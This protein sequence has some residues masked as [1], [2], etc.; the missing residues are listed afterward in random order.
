MDK[1]QC[2][3]KQ[4]CLVSN[5][6]YEATITSD[7]TNYG[8]KKYIGLCETTFKK[9]YA[10]HKTSFTHPKYKKSTT[11]S[12]EYWKVKEANRNPKI[13][14]KILK[15]SRAFSPGH[16]S[17]QLCQEEKYQIATYPSNNLLNKKTEIVSQCRHMNKFYLATYDSRD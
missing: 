2:P 15:T 3:M 5:V 1:D 7:I 11:L 10:S 17:C 16:N 8:E 12:T 4:N 13:D 6:I 14:W 9:R